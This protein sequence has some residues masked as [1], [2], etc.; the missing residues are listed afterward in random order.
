[1]RAD[2]QNC[3]I[4]KRPDANHSAEKSEAKLKV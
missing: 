1:M 2:K 3:S 4:E